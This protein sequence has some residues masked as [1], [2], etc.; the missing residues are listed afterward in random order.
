MSC[1]RILILPRFPASSS[2]EHV[3]D[4][5]QCARFYHGG[6][7]GYDETFFLLKRSLLSPFLPFFHTGGAQLLQEV[8]L[9]DDYR[10]QEKYGPGFFA[11]CFRG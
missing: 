7:A 10:E 2:V 4:A 9:D 5:A 6:R 3:D 11:C 1:L 8:T